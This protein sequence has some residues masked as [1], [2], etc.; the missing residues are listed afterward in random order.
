MPPTTMVVHLRQ[1]DN[2]R[3]FWSLLA[4]PW[5]NLELTGSEGIR[6]LE[7]TF[8]YCRT[9]EGKWEEVILNPIHISHLFL[10]VFK[11]FKIFSLNLALCHIFTTSLTTRYLLSS[12]WKYE[13]RTDEVKMFKLLEFNWLKTKVSISS[14]ELGVIG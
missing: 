12:T 9:P 1:T 2:W 14:D 4:K 3:L 7:M 6:D 13:L 8:A 10:V 11:E 5:R